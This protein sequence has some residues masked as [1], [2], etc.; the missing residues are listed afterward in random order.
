MPPAPPLPR[1]DAIV[2]AGGRA[3]RL[4]GAIKP[5]LPHRDSTLLGTALAAVH[6]AERRVVAGPQALASA[7]DGAEH[8]Q[9]DP[10]FGGPVAGLA[11]AL[12]LLDRPDAPEW[13]VVLAADLVAPGPAVQRL[14]EDAASAVQDSLLAVD[15]DGRAQQLLGVHR[16]RSLVDALAALGDPHGASVR[17]LLRGL[18]LRLVS[19]PAGSTDDVDAPTD[20]LRHGIDLSGPLGAH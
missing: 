5:L 10:P 17:A 4:G 2:L 13:V 1:C 20:A 16:R 8:V 3:T 15:T 19:V 6:G 9:E 12:P 18:P 7:L 11:A 14:L